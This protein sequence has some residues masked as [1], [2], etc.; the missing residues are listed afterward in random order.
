MADISITAS[1]VLA[2]SDA[3]KRTGVAGVAITAGQSLYIDTANSN[4]LKLADSDGTTP[5][6][7]FAGIALHSAA[8]GQPIQ[9]ALTDPSFTFGGTV[10]A[11][12]AIYLSDTP[13]G[14]T[15]TFSELET[16]DKV[17]VLGVALTTTT[18]NL[19]PVVGGTI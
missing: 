13:G 3:F 10:S 6:N 14:I 4:V 8:S 16:G 17:I 5:A 2:S 18:M 15:K 11:G 7:S 12:D 19:S 9:Y 1:S